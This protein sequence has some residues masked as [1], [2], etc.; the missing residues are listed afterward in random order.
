MRIEDVLHLSPPGFPQ[1]ARVP[2]SDLARYAPSGNGISLGTLVLPYGAAPSRAPGYALYEHEWEPLLGAPTTEEAGGTMYWGRHIAR[3]D[4]D[5]VLRV[6]HVRGGTRA[7][8][9]F[10]E[11]AADVGRQRFATQLRLVDGFALDLFGAKAQIDEQP[12]TIAD[13]LWRFME[14]E[15]DTPLDGTLGGDGDWAY[16]KVAFGF[17]VENAYRGVYRIWSRPWLVSK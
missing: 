8:L 5:A 2:P 7:Y 1:G 12:L 3:E 11:R 6:L 17:L 16:E 10:V 15:R 4:F 14:L 9:A 13:A